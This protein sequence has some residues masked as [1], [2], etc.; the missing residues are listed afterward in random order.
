MKRRTVGV[1]PK[2]PIQALVTVLV[3]LL[4]YFGVDLD[5]ET[6]AALAVVLGAI[7]GI[8]APAPR[9]EVKNG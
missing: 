6:S 9:T 1:D 7:A 2:V 5:K 4:A 8:L 3:A